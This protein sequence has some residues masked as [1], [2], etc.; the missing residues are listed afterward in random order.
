[1]HFHQLK[2]LGASVL[3]SNQEAVKWCNCVSKR[4]SPPPSLPLSLVLPSLGAGSKRGGSG[5]VDQ[6]EGLDCCTVA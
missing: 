4:L 6:N 1:M 2:T 5:R 3:V